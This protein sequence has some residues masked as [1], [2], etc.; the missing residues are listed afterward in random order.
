MA[1]VVLTVG[2][3]VDDDVGTMLQ[4][5]L[6]TRGE[7]A[8]QPLVGGQA[9]DVSASLARDAHGAVGRAV[10]DDDDLDLVDALDPPW[11]LGKGTRQHLLFVPRGDRM[12][13]FMSISGPGPAAP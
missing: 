5:R 3:R 7:A 1:G 9:D 6:D 13:S 11:Q 8:R 2:V 4:R 10:V 12:T